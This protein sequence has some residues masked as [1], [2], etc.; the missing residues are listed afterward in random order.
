VSAKIPSSKL[1]ENGRAK[2]ARKGASV[3]NR[4][5]LPAALLLSDRRLSPRTQIKRIVEKSDEINS[6]QYL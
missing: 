6:N 4:L 5:N 2:T 1:S 3:L